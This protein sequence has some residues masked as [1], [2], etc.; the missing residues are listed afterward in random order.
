MRTINR[1]VAAQGFDS[2]QYKTMS[3]AL[4]PAMFNELRDLA[5]ARAVPLAHVIRELLGQALKAQKA[6]PSSS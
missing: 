2:G 6:A 1:R 3:V 5:A 4:E